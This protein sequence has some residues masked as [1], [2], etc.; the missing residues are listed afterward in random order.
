MSGLCRERRSCH[1]ERSQGPLRQQERSLAALGMTMELYRASETHGHELGPGAELVA[2]LPF[3]CAVS[4]DIALLRL[5][6]RIET[7]DVD[8]F[9]AVAGQPRLGALVDLEVIVPDHRVPAVDH[10]F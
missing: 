7:L 6:G 8:P 1:P 10:P 4:H 3:R 2:Y 9:V 5:V